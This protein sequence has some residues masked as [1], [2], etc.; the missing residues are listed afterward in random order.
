MDLR[1][2]MVWQIVVVFTWQSAN[3]DVAPHACRCLLNGFPTTDV[4]SGGF[5]SYK[6]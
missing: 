6:I 5:R 2:E 3:L 1:V 4:E